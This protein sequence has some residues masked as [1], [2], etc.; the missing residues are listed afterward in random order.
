METNYEHGQA[1]LVFDRY[2]FGG[3]GIPARILRRQQRENCETEYECEI[4]PEPGIP[5]PPC[6]EKNRISWYCSQ[7]IRSTD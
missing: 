1:V 6:Q 7:Q 3:K 5:W 2:R 4:D